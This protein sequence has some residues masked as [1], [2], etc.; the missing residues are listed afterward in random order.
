[1]RRISIRT[2]MAFIVISAVGLAAVRS[3]SAAWAGALFSITFFALI[4]SFLGG[5][6]AIHFASG[7]GEGERDAVGGAG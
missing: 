2:L 6:T 1:M 3:G 7:R 4:S 5:W